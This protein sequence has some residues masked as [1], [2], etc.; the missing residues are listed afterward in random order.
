MAEISKREFEV[1][2]MAG[3]AVA[4]F[5]EN[6]KEEALSY[7]ADTW[8][9]SVQLVTYYYANAETI[10]RAEALLSLAEISEGVRLEH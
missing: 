5:A 6:E 10:W 2:D 9:G 4:W 7:A 3:E 8:C 1:L